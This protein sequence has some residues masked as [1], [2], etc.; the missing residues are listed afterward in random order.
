MPSLYARGQNKQSE[1]IVILHEQC[2]G[3][4]AEVPLQACSRYYRSYMRSQ[5]SFMTLFIR[6]YDLDKVISMLES[7]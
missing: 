7:V 3:P 4:F 1:W 5:Y 6:W 2:M